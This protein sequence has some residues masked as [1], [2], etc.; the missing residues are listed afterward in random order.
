M[1]GCATHQSTRVEVLEEQVAVVKTSQG[2]FVI[3]FHFDSAPATV[4]NFKN[5]VRLRF[6]NGLTFHRRENS[7][8]LSII[9]G[10]DPNGDGTGGPGYTIKDEYANPNQ[11]PH[12]RGTVAM[13]RTSAPNSA[14]SQFYICLKPQ[15]FLDGRYTTF[16]QVIKGMDVVDRLRVG[17]KMKTVK[18]EARS[19]HVKSE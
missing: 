4:E 9:Q 7:E 17:D 12:L 16:G 10:G 13:A 1:I 11:R 2:E 15:S 19:E 3:E 6:Y 5:L 14:G 18:L 8:S